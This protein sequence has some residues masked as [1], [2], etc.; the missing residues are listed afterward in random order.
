MNIK[1]VIVVNIKWYLYT[2]DSRGDRLYRLQ[3]GGARGVVYSCESIVRNISG[4]KFKKFENGRYV[5]DR[6][7]VDRLTRWLTTT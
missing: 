3:P 2:G 6:M 1:P 4:V 7:T 5:L